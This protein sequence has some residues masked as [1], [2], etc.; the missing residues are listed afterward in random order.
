MRFIP[1]ALALA[2]PLVAAV[3]AHAQLESWQPP[4]FNFDVSHDTCTLAI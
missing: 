4:Q 1:L 2:L 3:P